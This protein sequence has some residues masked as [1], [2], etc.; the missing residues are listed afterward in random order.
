MALEHFKTQVLL[1]HSQQ[2]TLDT[3]SAGFG[4]RYA[5]HLATTGTEALN[6]LGATPI[7]V[8]V[9]A[10]DLPGMSGLEALREAKKRSPDTI[11][12]LLAGSDPEDGLEALVGD[13]EVFQIVRG[14]IT[15]DALQNLIDTA[16][17]RVRMLT[18]SESAND[19]A[20]NVDE[21][22]GEHIVMETSENGSSIIS[23]GTG[24]LPILK[25]RQVHISAHAGGR[26]IDVL[27]LTKDE[28]FLE[29]I[30]DSSYESHAVHHANTPAQAET[31]VRNHKVG[32][33]VTDAAM[34]GSNIE[35]IMES[36][37]KDSPRLIAVVA[38]R[39]DDGEL[40]MDLINRGQVYRFLLKPV[41][42]GRARLAIE[43][44]VKHHLEAGDSA[45]KGKPRIDTP[46]PKDDRKPPKA[47]KVARITP[48]VSATPPPPETAAK[49]GPRPAAPSTVDNAKKSTTIGPDSSLHKRSHDD[50]DAAFG[51][52]GRFTRTMTGIAATV[53]KTLGGSAT[54]EDAKTAAG[55]PSTAAG[56]PPT[57][58]KPKFLSIGGGVCAI[59]AALV[60]WL[61]FADSTKPDTASNRQADPPA[62]LS[63]P[64][65][66]EADIPDAGGQGAPQSGV[67]V[68]A[69]QQL[70]DEARRARDAGEIVIPPGSNAIELY[71][72]AREIAPEEEA[73]VTELEQVLVTA[74]ALVE[75]ALLEQRTA[76]AAQTLRLVRLADPA[77]P[78][79]AFLD[80]Q[81]AQ[82]QLRISLDQARVA[83]RERRFEDAATALGNAEAAGG[84]GTPEIALLVEELS[85]ARSQ[86]RVG[87]VIALANQRVEQNALTSP[88]NDNARYYY[89]LALSNDPGNTMARQGLT[90]VASKLVLR[91]RE[92]ID[93]G[94]LD[95]AERFLLDA[96]ALD[97]QSADLSASMEALNAAKAE[98]EAA[99]VAEAERRAELER[100]AALAEAGDSGS[101]DAQ[102][103]PGG[104]S[105]TDVASST[106]PAQTQD[107]QE[108]LTANR[109]AGASLGYTPDGTAVAA[110]P[111][112]EN[113]VRDSSEN[114]AVEA[115]SSDVSADSGADPSAYVAI[116]TLKRSNYV[117]PTYPRSAL[118]RNITG[119]VDVSFTVSRGGNVVDVG[120][121]D[122]S[123]GDVF[124][125]AATEA[126]QQWRFEPN[127]EN[128]VPVEKRVA[129]R[130]M[131]SLE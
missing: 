26:D 81:L 117:A 77:N 79:L 65:V 82:L 127:V 112:A 14:A 13:K 62:A 52:S 72:A 23:D 122:S 9:S 50:L 55:D 58:F 115:N 80:A 113:F 64:S 44:S 105:G 29:T 16:T 70:L 54:A 2:S 30:R 63:S 93:T 12:I 37:R 114:L 59:V 118:R 130:L 73:I 20:A 111:A 38:G 68:P 104:E 1:L 108:E 119:W 91:A 125:G 102:A 32:V 83:I 110:D 7:H 46:P 56:G 61:G 92:A 4:D 51:D 74:I 76:D 94:Q 89:E 126:V 116:S 27:V 53:G 19:L 47:T 11:G 8:I 84:A 22:V 41:S 24:R 124:N 60:W 25:A 101:A 42:P 86:Q 10:Q 45:F 99:A 49:A 75:S 103:A 15:P 85:T 21:P 18:I 71:I 100:E 34:V 17:K 33:L 36:L 3:L 67:P 106:D 131:F 57:I 129:V 98:R 69:Y 95:E 128:G 28:D 123:P 35:V 31:I 90:I 48:K 107:S 109:A 66:V 120:I 6:T 97:P 5:V 88:S 39:R 40:L 43:A 121:L 78:R 96:N 87:E